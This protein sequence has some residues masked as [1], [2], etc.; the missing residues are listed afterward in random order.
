[1]YVFL[2]YKAQIQIP[3]PNLSPKVSDDGYKVQICYLGSLTVDWLREG[4]KKNILRYMGPKKCFSYFQPQNSKIWEG[5]LK[6]KSCLRLGG[7]GVT[8]GWTKFLCIS[9]CFRP[10]LKIKKLNKKLG[11]KSQKPLPQGKFPNFFF[12]NE[13]FSNSKQISSNY[14]FIIYSKFLNFCTFSVLV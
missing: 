3:S 10:C 13:P 5:L 9:G 1:M 2:F 11:K 6:K 7:G 12:F 4:S 14:A 8:K